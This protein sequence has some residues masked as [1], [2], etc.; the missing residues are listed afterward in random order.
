MRPWLGALLLA[1]LS[2]MGG[3]LIEYDHCEGP[4]VLGSELD[5]ATPTGTFDGVEVLAC[6]EAGSGR[7]LRGGGA[8]FYLGAAPGSDGRA[9]ALSAFLDERV[10]PALA[11][12]D[13]VWGSGWGLPCRA[14]APVGASVYLSD[15]RQMD[16]VLAALG[17]LLVDEDLAEEISIEVGAVPC[18]Q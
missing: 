18:A 6:D 13:A 2:A 1:V 14:D 17:D 5:V 10:R 15:W 7:H 16:G 11:P 9:D 12:F 4:G 8:A 3:C